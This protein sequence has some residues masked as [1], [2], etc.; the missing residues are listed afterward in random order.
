MVERE[1][2]DDQQVNSIYCC[3][4]ECQEVLSQSGSESG[5]QMEIPFT[6]MSA[7]GQRNRSRKVDNNA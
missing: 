7:E 2:G 6:T 1:R 5:P 4:V 3:L